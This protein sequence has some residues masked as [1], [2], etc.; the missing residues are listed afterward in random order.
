MDNDIIELALVNLKSGATITIKDYESEIDYD[1]VTTFFDKI[2]SNFKDRSIRPDGVY[3]GYL[4]YGH[5]VILMDEISSIIVNE[6]L[7][8]RRTIVASKQP[9]T[10]DI[11]GSAMVAGHV[12]DAS[13]DGHITE[14]IALEGPDESAENIVE[15]TNFN[16]PSRDF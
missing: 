15:R 11:V 13:K 2:L 9:G 7:Y 5:L 4:Q 10:V 3:G 12:Y 16:W 6:S 8:E 1:K 14:L